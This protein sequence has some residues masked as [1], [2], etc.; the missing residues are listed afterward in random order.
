[1][2]AS[3]REIAN[4]FSCWSSR[5]KLVVWALRWLR[6][7]VNQ[8]YKTQ[9]H[10]GSMMEMIKQYQTIIPGE[11]ALKFLEAECSCNNRV[12]EDSSSKSVA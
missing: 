5:P 10:V 6:Y 3:I 11:L 7:L 2:L 8:Q 1:M 4:S 9:T 12:M